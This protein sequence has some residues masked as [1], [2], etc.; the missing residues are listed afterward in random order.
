MLSMSNDQPISYATAKVWLPPFHTEH[1]CSKCNLSQLPRYQNTP[2]LPYQSRSIMWYLSMRAKLFAVQDHDVMHWHTAHALWKCGWL[3]ATYM[4][5]Y[6]GTVNLLCFS[7]IWGSSGLPKIIRACWPFV[8][9]WLA[10]C[11][12]EINI[13]VLNK[14]I[15]VCYSG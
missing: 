3:N 9:S 12:H 5:R 1:C 8:F 15:E 14:H 4:D 10:S 13:Q 11:L 2:T 7:C 6:I